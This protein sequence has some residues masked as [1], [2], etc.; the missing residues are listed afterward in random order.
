M[1]ELQGTSHKNYIRVE[2]PTETSQFDL[3]IDSHY[4]AVQINKIAQK[5]N[6]KIK[7]QL[8]D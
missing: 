2:M 5:I 8:V 1:H 4:M 3:D 6:S 7:I